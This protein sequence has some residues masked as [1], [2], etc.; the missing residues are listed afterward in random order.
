MSNHP[1]TEAIKKPCFECCRGSIGVLSC[2]EHTRDER[3]CTY[4]DSGGGRRWETCSS[5]GR[6]EQLSS[7]RASFGKE[8]DAATIGR[9][10]GIAFRRGEIT[11]EVANAT[12]NSD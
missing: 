9:L 4:L 12:K 2:L 3:E 11:G 5:G 8:I 6:S 7:Y 10:A 1:K